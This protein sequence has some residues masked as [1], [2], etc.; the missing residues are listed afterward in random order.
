MKLFRALFGSLI[1]SDKS[2]CTLEIPPIVIPACGRREST[3]KLTVAIP[4]KTFVT[5]SN[6]NSQGN[7]RVARLLPKALLLLAIL[8]ALATFSCR[9]PTAQETDL[10]SRRFGNLWVS[11]NK[12]KIVEHP[13]LD[14]KPRRFLHVTDR[15]EMV[16]RISW[17]EIF[18]PENRAPEQNTYEWK[19]TFPFASED[20]VR[21]EHL[22]YDLTRVDDPSEIGPTS[23]ALQK[24]RVIVGVPRS[25]SLAQSELPLRFIYSA[26]AAQVEME[27]L[28]GR[29]TFDR[30][31]PPAEGETW[32]SC[33]LP[34]P[35]KVSGDWADRFCAV[36]FFGE[37]QGGQYWNLET[38]RLF[39]RIPSSYLEGPP[40]GSVTVTYQIDRAG[41]DDDLSNP[42]GSGERETAARNMLFRRGEC[43]ECLR[44]SLYLPSPCEV[45]IPAFVP[46]GTDLSFAVA[47]IGKKGYEGTLTYRVAVSEPGGGNEPRVIFTRDVS[48]E[49]EQER[50][51]EA[52][53]VPLDDF[54]NRNVELCFSTTAETDYPW[55]IPGLV[56]SPAIIKGGTPDNPNIIFVAY[57]TQRAD[58]VGCYGY[59]KNTTPNADR[60]ASGGIRF[61]E[62]LSPS[63]WTLPSFAIAF[64]GRY[65]RSLGV[66]RQRY[67]IPQNTQTLAQSL[68]DAGYYTC[69]VVSNP[70]LH[71][72]TNMDLG[73]E[74]YEFRT[75][76]FD[77]NCAEKVTDTTIRWLSEGLPEPFF[78]FVHYIDPHQPFGLSEETADR[79]GSG[80]E[81]P[82]KRAFC[83]RDGTLYKGED[84]Q[85]IMDMYDG[86]CWYTDSEFGRL[87]DKIDGKTS[88]EAPSNSI[89][90]RTIIALM[91]DHG[92]EFWDHGGA[93]RGFG[94]PEY[95]RGL[96][97]GH[98]FYQ[99]LIRVML[100]LR[101]PEAVKSGF[102]FSTPMSLLDLPPTLLDL[103]G[104]DPKSLGGDIAGISLCNAVSQNG[105]PESAPKD[106]TIYMDSLLFGTPKLGVI[107]YPWKMIHHLDSG[108]SELYNLLEDPKEKTDVASLNWK[109]SESMLDL[110]IGYNR[111]VCKQEREEAL[112][113]TAVGDGSNHQYRCIL[114]SAQTIPQPQADPSIQTYRR[115]EGRWQ[116]LTISF[117]TDQPKTTLTFPL[118][119]FDTPIA[120]VFEI[121]G[122]PEVRRVF[123]GPDGDHP[124][125]F[126]L[127]VDL[128]P[129]GIGTIKS[130]SPADAALTEAA[131]AWTISV[132]RNYRQAA[133]GPQRE[134]MTLDEEAL[135]SL[136]AIGY[137][138]P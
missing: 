101:Y 17:A 81:G 26:E 43:D 63:S 132:T 91:S 9:R 16:E 118:G 102:V 134:L 114:R 123:C 50:P 52:H 72:G 33:R 76:V 100:I 23:Y 35:G 8:P 106:R 78:M 56:G 42:K 108:R 22:A 62:C 41:L 84:R 115:R 75:Y 32:W 127:R 5:Y 44:S 36:Y 34:V 10:P 111:D 133:G 112:E 45:R 71:P 97:H 131:P 20:E 49:S 92:E 129:T 103:A 54:A 60:L 116:D 125:E 31:Q 90:K 74:T 94:C 117:E 18:G 40:L 27:P 113:I 64:T 109:L 30:T 51:W 130:G 99:E 120:G 119:L 12:A 126:P 121:D 89:E 104:L 136:R 67:A 135:Q 55:H 37:K 85:R 122:K 57:D 46:P 128:L 107:Q 80:Y 98:T 11:L 53:R 73:F 3:C 65:P 70:F 110:I 137:T 95:D 79:F 93:D 29:W 105:D 38:A 19:P 69:G 14:S 25:L 15:P 61:D 47:P 28:F 83:D 96:D 21:V 87:L 13:L 88:G 6:L 138:G 39:V 58:H 68:A 48:L 66:E 1:P 86:D 124:Q 59:D 7:R 2:S 4:A 82:I 24:D 77:P